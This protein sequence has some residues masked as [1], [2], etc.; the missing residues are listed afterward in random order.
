MDSSSLS[1]LR[2]LYEPADVPFLIRL[3]LYGLI[4][5][6][7]AFVARVATEVMMR[8]DVAYEANPFSMFPPIEL[9]GLIIAVGAGVAFSLLF[10]WGQMQPHT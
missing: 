1:N 7:S 9:S 5:G 2:F 6:I 8:A 3:S 4:T 10:L